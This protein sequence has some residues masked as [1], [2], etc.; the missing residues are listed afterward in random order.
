[1]LTTDHTHTRCL[2]EIFVFLSFRTVTYLPEHTCPFYILAALSSRA[3]LLL[4]CSLS[5][6]FSCSPFLLLCPGEGFYAWRPGKKALSSILTWNLIITECNKRLIVG[7]LVSLTTL[8]DYITFSFQRG[9][10]TWNETFISFVCV[11]FQFNLKYSSYF[12]S[13]LTLYA[14]YGHYM[15][16]TISLRIIIIILKYYL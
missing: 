7:N 16:Y 8:T 11:G 12:V 14:C 10:S 13:S 6:S 9:C 1:M 5:C 4:I 3:F 2:V 15:E